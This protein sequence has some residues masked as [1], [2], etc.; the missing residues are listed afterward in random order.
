M[1]K[2]SGC[3][4]MILLLIEGGRE[5]GGG[6]GRKEGERRRRRRSKC[7]GL[8]IRGFRIRLDL[9]SSMSSWANDFWALIFSSV[10]G[11]REV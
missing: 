5:E 11:G 4:K 9:T 8:G 6:R 3:F 2:D 7:F 10:S 1:E